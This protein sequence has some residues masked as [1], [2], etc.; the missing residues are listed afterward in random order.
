MLQ[1]VG[2]E[3][4]RTGMEGRVSLGGGREG[5]EREIEEKRV[6]GGK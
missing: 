4:D 6:V 1:L 3:M 2:Q 5:V